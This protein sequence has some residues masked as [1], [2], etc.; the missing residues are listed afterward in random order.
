MAILGASHYDSACRFCHGTP[1]EECNATV[2]SMEPLPPPINEAVTQ[3]SAAE[4]GWITREGV[5][6]TGM[7]ALASSRDEEIWS[8]VA[9]LLLVPELRIEDYE[10]MV[11]RGLA[12]DDPALA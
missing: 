4:L 3:W 1:G 5:K 11:N 2:Q 8:V 6:M 9:F 7:P 12:P 10:S